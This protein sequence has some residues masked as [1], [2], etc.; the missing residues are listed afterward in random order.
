M[1]DIEQISGGSKLPS[2]FK[3]PFTHDSVDWVTFNFHKKRSRMFRN[4]CFHEA[5]VR[6][7]NGNTSGKQEFYDDDPDMLR[8]KVDNFI[9]SL[10]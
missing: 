4:G 6:L 10:K 1:P 8:K 7:E 5:I 9:N 2:E 3:D